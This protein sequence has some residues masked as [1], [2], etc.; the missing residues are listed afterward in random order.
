[1]NTPITVIGLTGQTGAGKTTVTLELEKLGCFV[2]DCDKLARE[3]VSPGSPALSELARRFGRDILNPDGSL[4]RKLLASRGFADEESR[5]A[6]NAVTHPAITK[7]ALE[8][9][10]CAA[11]EGFS[12]AVI[13][14]AALLESE[15]KNYCD[16]LVS[17]IAPA[18][19]RLNRILARDGITREQAEERMAAQK[20]EEYYIDN[21]DIIIRNYPP[22]ELGDQ[23][24]ELKS[25]IKAKETGLS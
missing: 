18:P 8:C 25:Y 22:F 14:G 19:V 11:G 15:I 16:I 13:D 1:M 2:I 12:V 20:N 4:D 10:D 9:V 6:L 21:S 5:K 3:I 17:V 24:K 7:K 23:M